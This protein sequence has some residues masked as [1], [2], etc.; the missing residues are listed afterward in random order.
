MGSLPRT[1]TAKGEKVPENGRSL[2]AS[3]RTPIQLQGFIDGDRI[4]ATFF[5]Q[6]AIRKTNG[7]VVWK[8]DR[9]SGG[10]TGTFASTAAQTT[11][12]STA[13]REL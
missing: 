10:L 8:I 6:G 1:F 5:E 11:G 3:S 9:S 4:E 7:R 2:P 12:K 13:R